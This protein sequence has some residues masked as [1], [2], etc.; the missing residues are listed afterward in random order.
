MTKMTVMMFSLTKSSSM[1]LMTMTTTME[2]MFM[3]MMI[4]KSSSMILMIRFSRFSTSLTGA[5]T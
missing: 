4:T 5:H 3:M 2:V 1:I